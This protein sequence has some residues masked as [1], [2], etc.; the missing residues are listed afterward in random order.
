MYLND[1]NPALRYGATLDGD[2]TFSN[3]GG[4]LY[5]TT[6]LGIPFCTITS[7]G[8]TVL[9]ADVTLLSDDYVTNNRYVYIGGFSITGTGAWTPGSGSPIYIKDGAGTIFAN[10]HC[11]AIKQAVSWNDNICSSGSLAGDLPTTGSVTL[12]S[13]YI[14][15]AKGTKSKGLVMHWDSGTIETSTG[16]PFYVTIWGVIK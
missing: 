2:I 13:S 12:T 15:G 6:D 16:S 14:E 11:T 9:D 1:Y 8:T 3:A 4:S 7:V 10:I 5:C